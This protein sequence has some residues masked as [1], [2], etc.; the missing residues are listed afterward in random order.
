MLTVENGGVLRLEKRIYEV[1]K[2]DTEDRF[3]ALS[4]NDACVKK[5]AL[6]IQG[7]EDVTVE[8]NG[9]VLLCRD[10]ITAIGIADSRRVTV[11]NLTIDYLGNR[12]LEVLIGKTNGNIAEVFP[13]EGFPF[14]LDGALTAN[15]E[16]IEKT[17]IMQFDGKALRPCYRMN[18]RFADF[19]QT[20]EKGFY[21]SAK[22]YREDG[23]YYIRIDEVGWLTEGNV[24]MIAYADRSQQAVF[25]HNS[26]DVCFENVTVC[27]SPSMAFMC[28]LTDNLTLRNITV[29]ANGKHGVLSSL[30]DATH[31]TH[32]G[33]KVTIVNGRFFHMMDDAV[34]VHGNYTVVKA[35]DGKRITAK[36]MHRQQEGVN[37]LPV[38]DTVTV[39]Q[40][41]T[42][43][44]KAF[45]RV[46]KS[47]LIEAG[48]IALEADEETSVAVGD[49]LYNGGRMPEVEITATACG[50]NRPRGFLLTT[51]KRAVVRGCRFS[52]C[53]HGI[54]LAGDTSYWFESGGCKEVLIEDCVF[55]NCNY[56]DGQ[57][58]IVVRPTF[59]KNGKE[60]F[61]H[62]NI[63]VRGNRFVGFTGGMV[64]ARNAQNL[65]IKDNTYVFDGTFPKEEAKE[66]MF[67]LIDC[68][69]VLE[70]NG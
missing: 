69:A 63:T 53:E 11:R 16:L 14:S 13:R 2:G 26:A 52:N 60:K 57:Y 17:L 67:S 51:P 6:H 33:G 15:G 47:E 54:E 31:F 38:G 40:G 55:D 42:I 21:Q 10:F 9:A 66:G 25:V 22:L 59:D 41:K 56:T 43:D 23:R 5:I 29:A 46:A 1:G 61:Y 37:V 58:P 49:T 7:K 45:F 8:G 68:E 36:I 12:H 64:W 27:Y 30:G 44:E 48:R 62:K 24:L 3:Y 34:N 32:C 4:N 28:Q 20:A 50:N 39:Y 18:Y 65:V 35:V 70:N 19:G